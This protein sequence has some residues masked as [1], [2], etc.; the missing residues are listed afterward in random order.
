AGSPAPSLSLGHNSSPLAEAEDEP[1]Q[2]FLVKK[3]SASTLE[4]IVPTVLVDSQNLTDNAAS[5]TII[6][7]TTTTWDPLVFPVYPEVTTE[8]VDVQNDTLK[9]DTP[10]VGLFEIAIS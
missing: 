5:E 1:L 4:D 9:N 3:Q 2:E 6:I 10:K 7:S 8:A